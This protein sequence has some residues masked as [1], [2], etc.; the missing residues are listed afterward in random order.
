M[1]RSQRQGKVTQDAVAILP[2][3]G[4][5]TWGH[6][7]QLLRAL[8]VT[9]A[10]S[11]NHRVIPRSAAV[12]TVWAAGRRSEDAL[13]DGRKLVGLGALTAPE[14]GTHKKD[15]VV[16]WTVGHHPVLQ[17]GRVTRVRDQVARHRLVVVT[18]SEER[19]AAHVL[20]VL[21][22]QSSKLLLQ[23]CSHLHSSLSLRIRHLSGMYEQ[24]LGI[25][26]GLVRGRQHR[27]QQRCGLNSGGSFDRRH[28]IPLRCVEVVAC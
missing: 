1:R 18:G 9:E 11:H 28:G 23:V 15:A 6:R 25:R 4:E 19:V 14:C 22:L 27:S 16:A 17:E 2:R 24:V 12:R 13:G 5:I 3:V 7:I 8:P 10:H 21:V 26:M 20:Q